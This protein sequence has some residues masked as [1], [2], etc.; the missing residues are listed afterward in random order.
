MVLPGTRSVLVRARA[1]ASAGSLPSAAGRVEAIW[2]PL[3]PGT[4]FATADAVG[5]PEF[6]ASIERRQPPSA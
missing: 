4:P 6:L 5:V 1:P 2:Q 3:D